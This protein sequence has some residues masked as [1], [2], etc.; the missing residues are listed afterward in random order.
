M[1]PLTIG[2][3][4]PVEELPRANEARAVKKPLLMGPAPK[5]CWSF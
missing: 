3:R 2:M 1:F 4:R 5:G